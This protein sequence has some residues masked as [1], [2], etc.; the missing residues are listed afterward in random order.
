MKGFLSSGVPFHPRPASPGGG[1]WRAVSGSSLGGFW[2][3]LLGY[4]EGLFL[5]LCSLFSFRF[6]S[7]LTYLEYAC[8]SFSLQGFYRIV[9]S[10]LCVNSV[11]L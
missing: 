5:T 7:S 10:H 6:L 4:F 3:G 11:V 1:A 2:G 8:I 9:H